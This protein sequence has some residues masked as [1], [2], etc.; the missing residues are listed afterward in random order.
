MDLR[1]IDRSAEMAITEF[2]P[3]SEKTKDKGKYR[4]EGIS[5]SL[6]YEKAR[7]RNPECIVSMNPSD[8]DALH[9]CYTMHIDPNSM[10]DIS[11]WRIEDIRVNEEIL[12]P[13]EEV[14]HNLQANEKMLIIPQAYRSYKLFQNDGKSVDSNDRGSHF[15][16]AT[17]FAKDN[18]NSTNTKDVKNVKISAYGLNLNDE[19]EVWH[20]N[21]NKNQMFRGK[22]ASIN[23]NIDGVV[24]CHARRCP[25][26][27]SFELE[28]NIGNYVCRTCGRTSDETNVVNEFVS[29][30]SFMFYKRNVIQ[31][32][33]QREYFNTINN[34]ERFSFD[35]V[36]GSRK[37]TE[38][39]KLEIL[40]SNDYVDLNLTT[41][42]EP[43][44][45]AA[46]FS[47]AFLLQRSLADKLDVSPDE[48][49]ISDKIENGKPVIY[50]SDAAPNGAG[51]VSYLYQDNNL[52]EMLQDITEFRTAFMQSL[53]SDKHRNSCKTSC[54]DC[55][56]TYN[57]RG[58]HH[59]LDWRL[60]VSILRL[61]LN[62]DFDFGFNPATRSNYPELS[63]YNALVV[64]CAEKLRQTWDSGSYWKRVR[65]RDFDN[66]IIYHPLWNKIRLI[67][68]AKSDNIS[69]NRLAIYNTF[70]VL[71]SDLEPDRQ[72]DNIDQIPAMALDDQGQTVDPNTGLVL[73]ITL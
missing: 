51:I 58:F 45:R 55:L 46:F 13:K 29:S 10:Q 68:M 27:R 71:R 4:V 50:L 40:Y 65:I 7:G 23:D 16:Q 54:Q 32:N 70:H 47:A 63:D 9:N 15:S 35:I 20:V 72:P 64:E 11:T 34:G 44:I 61:M 66:L 69:T 49:E 38:M 60:G 52:E 28:E 42:N 73:G 36:I 18:A 33:P 24:T 14:A 67:A 2:A 5:T 53:I 43:A 62:P 39:I 31:G 26:C 37:P 8:V 41:G 19:A 6:R 57:N 21:T 3:G 30:N 56:L 25:Y 22:Y 12:T 48:I 59:V 17:I 1:E